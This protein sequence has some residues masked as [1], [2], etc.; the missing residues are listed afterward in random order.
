[1][2]IWY[3]CRFCSTSGRDSILCRTSIREYVGWHIEPIA[4]IM[5]PMAGI[6]AMVG[7]PLI[8]YCDPIGPTLIEKVWWNRHCTGNC[9]L[10]H[11]C[12]SQSKL[13]QY[14]PTLLLVIHLDVSLLS[15]HSVG[16]TVPFLMCFPRNEYRLTH[17]PYIYR[18]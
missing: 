11:H 18:L 15:Q 5:P 8:M 12:S 7:M 9:L 16:H 10:T 6:P 14:T 1:M 3:A 13:R 2:A 4:P 17:F